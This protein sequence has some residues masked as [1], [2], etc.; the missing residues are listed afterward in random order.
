MAL[1]LGVR[2]IRL[3]DWDY[4]NQDGGELHAGTVTMPDGLSGSTLP[5][6][7]VFIAWD[8]GTVANYLIDSPNINIRVFDNAQSGTVFCVYLRMIK[9]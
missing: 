6:N 4:G 5:K 7:V 9:I 1:L 2:V 8:C 3:G